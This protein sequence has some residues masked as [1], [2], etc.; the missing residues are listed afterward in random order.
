MVTYSSLTKKRV[1]RPQGKDH[2]NKKSKEDLSPFLILIQFLSWY[3]I[4]DADMV[5][6]SYVGI[7]LSFVIMLNLL[8][9]A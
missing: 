4:Y 7:T 9:L 1:F 5:L 8:F 2:L 3:F 6:T